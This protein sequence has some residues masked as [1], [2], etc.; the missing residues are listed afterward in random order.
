MIK[1]QL[2]DNYIDELLGV[3]LSEK[4]DWHFQDR[5]TPEQTDDKLISF[6]HLFYNQITHKT[7]PF[8]DMLVPW[9]NK[10]KIETGSPRAIIRIKANLMM[11]TGQGV[12]EHGVHE[13][14]EFPHQGALLSLNTCNGYTRIEDKRYNSKKGECII[15][16]PNLKHTGSTTSNAGY[17]CNIITNY[18]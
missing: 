2:E 5:L 10:L 7:S 17:R 11:N 1:L 9:L 14:Y 16:N 13:D 6:T 4:F 15:F 12:V 18:F 8:F 3:M